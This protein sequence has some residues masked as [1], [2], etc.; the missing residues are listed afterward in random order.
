[1][2]QVREHI[3]DDQCPGL[4]IRPSHEV[5]VID[6]EVTCRAE[7]SVKPY[8]RQERSENE[9]RI[10]LDMKRKDPSEQKNQDKKLGQ[11][12]KKRPKDP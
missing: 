2:D 7:A 9:G 5:T 8:P 6:E 12:R 11:W 10:G 3:D 4:E 1:M